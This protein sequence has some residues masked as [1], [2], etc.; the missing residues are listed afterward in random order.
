MTH[1]VPTSTLIN[2]EIKISIIVA[3]CLLVKHK[4][5]DSS[6]SQCSFND[7]HNILDTCYPYETQLDISGCITA[8]DYHSYKLNLQCQP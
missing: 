1:D 6:S 5:S 2:E 8:E 7:N 3:I 4:S